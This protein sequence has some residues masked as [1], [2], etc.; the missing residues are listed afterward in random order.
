MTA[1]YSTTR[2]VRCEMDIDITVP[3]ENWDTNYVEKQERLYRI[4]K[5]KP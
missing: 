4:L 2:G 1:L 5:A 3:H